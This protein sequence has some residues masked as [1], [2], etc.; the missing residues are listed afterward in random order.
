MSKEKGVKLAG[1]QRKDFKTLFGD[2]PAH[3]EIVQPDGVRFTCL[4]TFT[5]GGTRI[6]RQHFADKC[7]QL[8]V[9]LFKP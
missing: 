7:F 5:I 1:F 8:R 9:T 4:F 6:L 2:A 3:V